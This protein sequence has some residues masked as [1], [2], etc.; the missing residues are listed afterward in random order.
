M[1]SRAT[2]ITPSTLC[3]DSVLD[4]IYWGGICP[5]FLMTAMS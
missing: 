4:M 2:L 3:P 5:P 1:N